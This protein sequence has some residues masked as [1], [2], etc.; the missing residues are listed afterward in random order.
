MV[1]KLRVFMTYRLFI[2]TFLF[3][4]LMASFT[5]AAQ[6]PSKAYVRQRIGEVTHFNAKKNVRSQLRVSQP[7]V[8]HDSITTETESEAILSLPDG[9]LLNIR[10]RSKIVIED[11]YEENG[12]F[13]TNVNLVAGSMKF[14]VQKQNGNSTFNFKTGTMAAA[15]RGTEG[16]ISGG[17][18]FLAGLEN[19]ALQ[20]TKAN[21]ETVLIHGGQI[22]FDKDSLVMMN[23]MA[24]G[25]PAFH[26]RILKLLADSTLMADDLKEQ[27][28]KE[29]TL[30]TK[31]VEEA[32]QQVSCVI[33]QL[34]DTI[35]TQKIQIHG[36][37]SSNA[38]ASF[39]GEPV[40]LDNIGSFVSSVELDSIALGEKIFRLS[41]SVGN[42][43]FDCAEAR[44]YYKPEEYREPSQVILSTKT[45]VA[46]CEE[47]L[48]VEGTY[49]TLDSA[50][51]LILKIEKSYKSGN[52]MKKAD[53][54]PHPFA[55]NV[56]ISDRN[57]LWNAKMATLE[58]DAEGKKSVVEIP[59][60]VNRACQAVNQNSPIIEVN[61][62]DSLQCVANISI[63]AMQEDAGIFRTNIDDSEG[64]ASILN[65]NTSTKVK[66]KSGIH[67][68]DFN[69]KDQ[70]GNEASVVKTLGCFPN[71][72]F[73]IQIKNTSS[74]NKSYIPPG[75]PLSF[76]KE[77]YENVHSTLRFKIDLSDVS[78]VYSV[79][80]KQNGRKILHEILSQIESLD[81]DVPVNLHRGKTDRFEI[82]VKHKNG[83]VVTA[84]KTLEV[85]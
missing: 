49:Q 63:G 18:V 58:F 13:K 27:I 80:I 19:G 20:V 55:L 36:H 40:Q 61:G 41:C 70:A 52:L 35:S 24:G 11:F 73:N 81:Y 43:K 62:Y 75:D 2:K 3:I 68:Y 45:P 25:D 28:L 79:T 8:V 54:K 15:I 37:C 21:G 60:Q 44:T 69:V 34:P 33:D 48:N 26:E 5:L 7:V 64:K 56:A 4:A 78:E 50:A 30:Y 47:G 82:I 10:E 57:G 31:S 42:L 71:K 22:V 76:S 74:Y 84:T 53:G 77:G 67:E 12:A 29:D 17:D 65:K 83:R 59:L 39:Y 51:T 66:L 23:V 14:S 6:N 32:E 38:N 16:T 85:K 1:V 72:F 46:V 9:S